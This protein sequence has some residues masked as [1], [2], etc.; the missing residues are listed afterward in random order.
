MYS[1]H[2]LTIPQLEHEMKI[3][4]DYLEGRVEELEHENLHLTN[5]KKRF[6]RRL[7]KA[8]ERWK[9]EVEEK[10]GEVRVERE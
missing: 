10:E 5:E 8:E 9:K 6:D 7:E 1:I 2:L 3:H 4:L